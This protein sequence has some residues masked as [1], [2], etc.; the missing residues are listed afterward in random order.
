MA[1]S[2]MTTLT[3][4]EAELLVRA[5]MT[6]EEARASQVRYGSASLLSYLVTIDRE[7][8]LELLQELYDE[9]V[10]V[11]SRNGYAHQK[12]VDFITKFRELVAELKGE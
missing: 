5:N 4:E 10:G 12:E 9:A 7:K 8:N 11:V 2:T 1:T 3:T 6:E